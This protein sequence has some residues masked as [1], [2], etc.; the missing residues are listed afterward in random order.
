[1]LLHG[2][3]DRALFLVNTQIN[4][5]CQIYQ[6]CEHLP[7]SKK[8]GRDGASIGCGLVSHDLVRP[9]AVKGASLPL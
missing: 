1:M 7:S 4:V 3:W 2:A 5:A 6:H 8:F 9:K